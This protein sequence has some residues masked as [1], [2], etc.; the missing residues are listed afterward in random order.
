MIDSWVDRYDIIDSVAFAVM[1][2]TS[3]DGHVEST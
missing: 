3:T 2:G 1:C